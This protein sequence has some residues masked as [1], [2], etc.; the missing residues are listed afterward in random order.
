MFRG[1]LKPALLTG[2][3]G[4][5]LFHGVTFRHMH[6][7]GFAG[8]SGGICR[9]GAFQV[10]ARREPWRSPTSSLGPLKCNPDAAEQG[11][12]IGAMTRMQGDP[13]AVLGFEEQ[14]G[15][16]DRLILRGQNFCAS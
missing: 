1:N 6:A 8:S 5:L 3:A 7:S 13:D 9:I 14:S 12:R 11:I 2:G 16:L 10:P 15:K 4:F